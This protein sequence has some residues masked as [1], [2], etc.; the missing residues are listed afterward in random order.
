MKVLDCVLLPFACLGFFLACFSG[1]MPMDEPTT[2]QMRLLGGF[3][4]TIF[5]TLTYTTFA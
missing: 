4:I 2:T 3:V 5:S 1:V